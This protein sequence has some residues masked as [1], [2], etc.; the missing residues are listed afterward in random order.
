MRLFDWLDA[1]RAIF[2]VK[3]TN[4]MRWVRLGW[5]GFITQVECI[6]SRVVPAA[7]I[8]TAGSATI[9]MNSP[10]MG[11]LSASDPDA[12]SVTFSLSGTGTA[13][14]S[15]SLSPDGSFNYTPNSNYEGSDSFVFVVADGT[16]DSNAATLAVRSATL[17]PLWT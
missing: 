16:A 9:H 13:N 12:D 10:L 7:P 4:R 5:R 1:V 2:R 3:A 8:A 6:E 17:R 14:G 15:I 11:A